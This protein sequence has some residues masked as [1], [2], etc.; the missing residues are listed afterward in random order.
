MYKVDNS[1]F[2]V[3]Y[4]GV[5]TPTKKQTKAQCSDRSVYKVAANNSGRLIADKKFSPASKGEIKKDQIKVQ[6]I[7]PSD[8][9]L[10][11]TLTGIDNAQ[12]N[13]NNYRNFQVEYNTDAVFL[14]PKQQHKT[15]HGTYNQSQKANLP[16]NKRLSWLR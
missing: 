11:V 4:P 12:E 13:A 15:E 2:Y 6:K 8:L 16:I 14:S 10:N 5:Q 3:P 7:D 9:K 1:T